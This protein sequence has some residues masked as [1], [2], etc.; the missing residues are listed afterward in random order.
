MPKFLN[1]PSDFENRYVGSEDYF[2]IELE[3]SDPDAE[4]IVSYKDNEDDVVEWFIL[5]NGYTEGYSFG[6]RGNPELEGKHLTLVI[7]T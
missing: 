1:P 3:S 5:V 7:E 6:I 2:E 4:I